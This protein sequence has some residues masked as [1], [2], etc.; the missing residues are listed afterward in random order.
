AA[1]QALDSAR[2]S[3]KLDTQYNEQVAAAKAQLQSAQ[4]QLAFSEKNLRESTIRSPFSGRVTGKP[5]QAGVVV[6]SGTPIVRVIGSSG[7]YFEGQAPSDKVSSIVPGTPVQVTFDALKGR[8]AQGSVV[9]VSPQGDSVG[10]LFNV[11][12][13]FDAASLG[14]KPGMFA[15]GVITLAKHTGAVMVPESVII[16]RDN[17]SYVFLADGDKA[18]RQVVTLGLRKGSMVEVMGLSSGAQVIN[19]GQTSLV[20]GSKIKV[21]TAGA[22]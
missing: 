20:D 11:R 13:K 5:L 22:K 7:I 9:A 6:G 2:T 16:E 4:A 10:R 21:E 1:E 8:E 15:R 14:A 12:V 3:R 19:K 18:K 17:E